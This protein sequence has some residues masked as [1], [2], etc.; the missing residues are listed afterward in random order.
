RHT[1]FSRDWSSDVCS[2]DL[3]SAD[4]DGHLVRIGSERYMHSEGIRLDGFRELAQSIR[5]QGKTA[6]FMAVGRE[7]VAVFGVADP[8]K[9]TARSE[10]HTSELQSRENL[11]CR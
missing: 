11:V 10:E 4:V 2:S 9:E 5:Q 8:I 3:A 7:P 1:T 6:V